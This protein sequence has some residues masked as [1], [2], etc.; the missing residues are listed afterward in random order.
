MTWANRAPG[1]SL[2]KISGFEIP[3][4]DVL[5]I[6]NV[7]DNT[8]NTTPACYGTI[9]QRRGNSPRDPFSR[10]P[11]WKMDNWV[12]VNASQLYGVRNCIFGLLLMGKT[13]V[14]MGS[15]FNGTLS[16]SH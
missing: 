6:S 10:L 16:P 5:M 9:G 12:H 11:A 13:T 7:K 2:T 1:I 14:R 4:S 8:N 3:G 15:T